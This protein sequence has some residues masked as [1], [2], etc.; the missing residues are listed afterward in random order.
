MRTEALMARLVSAL[1][2]RPARSRREVY[3]SPPA[4]RLP[5][6]NSPLSILQTLLSALADDTRVDLSTW[7][8]LPEPEHRITEA[9][10]LARG[11]RAGYSAWVTFD[12]GSD[13]IVDSRSPETRWQA[14]RSLIPRSWQEGTRIVAAIAA[15]LAL[16]VGVLEGGRY[17]SSLATGPDR[18][19]LP[20]PAPFAFQGQGFAT[21]SAPSVAVMADWLASPYRAVFVYIGGAEVG[22]PWG[23]LSRSWV[24]D[25]EA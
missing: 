23:N 19:A 22:C 20:G 2:D 4:R 18:A 24:R 17:V 16:I 10:S 6:D 15:S 3:G 13:D 21:C 7:R 9:P 25:V 1:A 5:E 11:R 12:S 14:A 8:V